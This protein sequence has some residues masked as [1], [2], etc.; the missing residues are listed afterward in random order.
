MGV[1]ERPAAGK[2]IDR[3]M[4]DG[5]RRAAGTRFGRDEKTV[6]FQTNR[7][8]NVCN[9]RRG[10]T[11]DS[12]R[13][14]SAEDRGPPPKNFNLENEK[15]AMKAT[16]HIRQPHIH[17]FA[18]F[19][20]AVVCG[21]AFVCIAPIAQAQTDV[22]TDDSAI[23]TAA[24][25]VVTGDDGD[26][27]GDEVGTA[28]GDILESRGDLIKDA[29]K[30]ALYRSLSATQFQEAIDE[31]LDNRRESV[32]T[33]FELRDLNE[34]ERAEDRDRLSAEEVNALA[35]KKAPKRLSEDELDPQTGK[36]D[37]E[38]PLAADALKTYRRPIEESFEKR[39]SPGEEYGAFDYYKVK[40]MVNLMRESLESIKDRMDVRAFVA[41]DGYLDRVLHEAR[42]NSEGERVDY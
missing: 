6:P 1:D 39:V 25:P 28:T 21:W 37:W 12:P 7:W 15:V 30:A 41:M 24:V 13:Q 35:K 2:T 31:R 27:F 16:P 19:G 36:I 38:G 20:T 42:F 10:E 22:V 17:P 9:V 5:C 34:R 23:G 18:R 32:K 40:R 8:P 14:R 4:K 11:A 3:A 33:Y 29:G 26:G